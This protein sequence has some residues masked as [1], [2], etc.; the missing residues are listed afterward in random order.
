MRRYSYNLLAA[1]LSF[2]LGVFVASFS[3]VILPR[4]ADVTFPFSATD[5]SCDRRLESQCNEWEKTGAVSDGLGWDLTYMSLLHEAGVCPGDFY[6]EIATMKPQPPVHKHFAEWKGD[7]IVSSVLLEIP[8]GHRSMA[9]S[10]LIRTKDHAYFWAFHPE[11]PTDGIQPMSTQD[12]DRAFETITCWNQDEP[13]KRKFYDKEGYVGFL[14]M[15]KEGKSRQILLTYKDIWFSPDDYLNEAK[16]GRVWK[17]FMHI[18]EA[19]EEQ[20]RVTTIRSK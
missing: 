2:V 14:S 5:R 12:Y 15:F 19:A 4:F 7:P 10:W 6:C 1:L 16:W 3:R 17:T 9:A 8:D 13:L 18:H 20:R 11:Y